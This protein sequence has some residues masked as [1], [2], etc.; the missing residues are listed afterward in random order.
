MAKNG[1]KLDPKASEKLFSSAM[2]TKRKVFSWRAAS[3]IGI[4]LARRWS[5]RAMAHGRLNWNWRRAGT[6]TNSS[7]MALGVVSQAVR[8]QSAPIAFP[9]PSA[10]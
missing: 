3:T 4:P 5:A 10:P 2:A 6:S 9:T 7:W 8:M 1:K